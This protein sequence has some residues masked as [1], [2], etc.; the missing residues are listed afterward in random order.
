VSPVKLAPPPP[1]ED[2]EEEQRAVSK[3]RIM[4]ELNEQD[5]KEEK[6]L[7]LVRVVYAIL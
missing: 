3:L 6:R 5:R 4:M 1:K 7:K 2:T